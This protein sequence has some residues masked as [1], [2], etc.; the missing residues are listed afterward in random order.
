[1]ACCSNCSQRSCSIA[2]IFLGFYNLIFVILLTCL[3]KITLRENSITNL[4]QSIYPGTPIYGLA[5]SRTLYNNNEMVISFY[6]WGGA[7]VP[8]YSPPKNITKIYSTQFFQ[9][10]DDKSFIEYAKDYSVPN[11]ENCKDNYKK[12]GL[13]NIEGRVLCLPNDEDCPLND[14]VISD[15]NKDSDYPDYQKKTVSYGSPATDKYFYYTNK[16]TDNPIIVDLKL[17]NGL[18]CME[19]KEKSWFSVSP[20]EIE[21]GDALECKTSINGKIHDDRYTLSGDEI[22]LKNL[23]EDNDIIVASTANS[24]KVKLFKRN[25][26]YSNSDCINDFFGQKSGAEIA[27]RVL[28]AIS[29]ILIVVLIVYSFSICCCFVDYR[30]ILIIAPIFEIIFGIIGLIMNY[31]VEPK[32]ECEE[33]YKDLVNGFIKADMNFLRSSNI[34]YCIFSLVASI[35]ILLI[36]ICMR[37]MKKI[38]VYDRSN[39]RMVQVISQ[40]QPVYIQQYPMNNIGYAQGVPYINAA[41]FNN[42]QIQNVNQNQNFNQNQMNYDINSKNNFNVQ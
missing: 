25:Y 4:K 12:C 40:N 18:P 15:S 8:Q 11:G 24:E 3:F 42:N 32:Y 33:E 19:P 26:I 22:S 2:L 28:G 41:Q 37:N 36:C 10:I 23:Y 13:L 34:I 6:T 38:I 39:G 14:F 35:I 20:N 29:S 21:E 31:T 16:K 5:F 7:K 9:K 1:M 27:I 30:F 17:S